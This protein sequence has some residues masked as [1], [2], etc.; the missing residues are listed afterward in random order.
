MSPFLRRSCL[1][2]LLGTGLAGT[3]CGCFGV[4]QNPS[5]FPYLLPTG[6]IIQTHAKP[7]GKG[8]FADFDPHAC[9]LVVRPEEATNPV[10]TQQVF[11]ATIYDDKGKPRRDRRVEWMLEGVGN[12]V[13]VD[14]SG[15][16]PGRGY[17]V[18]NKYAVSYTDYFEHRI[19]RGNANPNDD[20]V[21][22]PGQSWCVVSSAVEGD[23]HLTVYAPEIFDWDRH[24]VFVTTHW[25]DAEWLMPQPAVNRAGEQHVFTTN[26]FRHTDRAPLA[27]Y[28]VRYRI[29]DGPPAMFLPMHSQEVEA[30]TDLRGNANVTIAQAQ[31]QPGVNRIGIEIIRP[32]D[33]CSP[34]GAGII[35]G[36]GETTK[37][38]QAPSLAIAKTG[39]P[40]VAVAAEIP[41]TITITNNGRIDTQG[42]TVRDSIPPGLQLVRAN[43]QPIV[44]GA[45]LIWTLA[46]LPPGANHALQVV[47]RAPAQ[48]GQVTNNVSVTSAEG[49]RAETSV[50]TQ[51]VAPQLRLAKTGP[52]TGFVNA[53]ITYQISVSN[54]GTAAI[55]NIA[56]TDTF[57][58]GLE[59]ESRAN[60][61]QVTVQNLQPGETKVVP[62]VL[63]PRQVGRL[64]NRVRATADGGLTAQAE[65][66][67]V[68]QQAQVGINISGPAARYVDRPAIWDI[69]VTN[70]G[71]SGL[72]NVVVRVQ[73]PPQLAFVSATDGGQPADSQVVWNLG[74]LPPRLP[75]ALQ[76]T[77]R[78]QAIAPRAETVALVTADPGLRAQA[79]AAVEIRGLPAFLLVVADAGDP[80]EVGGK[81]RYTIEVTNQGSLPGNRVEVTAL[82]PPEMQI[83]T[84]DGPSKPAIAGQRI[85]F[86]PVDSLEPKKTLQY[87]VDVQALRPGDVRFRAELRASTLQE[88]VAKEES[89]TIYAPLANGN[90]ATRT[91][92]APPVTNQPPPSTP[93]ARS[94]TNPPPQMPGSRPPA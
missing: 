38:W 24:K 55:N 8:Y 48:P 31:S 43:P 33:P 9:S 16:F 3:V 52:D 86:P 25:V 46:G 7:P 59:H 2:I 60:P 22:R 35:I 34:S 18:D 61:V 67:V 91:P 29:L 56:L 51:I 63:T 13:E 23:T 39:P 50:T 73:L 45:Q 66:P 10:R 21:I 6:D 89:T 68:V 47:F 82:V 42:L 84:A 44:E 41:Y 87:T 72:N 88:P 57:D 30:V 85:T 20:F 94:G 75:R 26:V 12:I 64:V 93:P 1:A 17:K 37:E 5:Y 40:S 58:A 90:G 53:P 74:V 79:Q 80:A 36:R 11:V 14:E 70:P 19:T 83:V 15:Y 49:A 71:D 32:P 92:A 4:S 81:V 78:C 76:L 54:P 62:L 77:T 28:R 69:Q 65:H 27:N